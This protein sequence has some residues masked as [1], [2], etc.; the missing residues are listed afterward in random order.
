[1]KREEESELSIGAH[2]LRDFTEMSF[3]RKWVYEGLA[4][5]KSLDYWNRRGMRWWACEGGS[6]V[7]VKVHIRKCES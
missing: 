4:T 6:Y 3:T 5:D 1:M 2:V 7:Q